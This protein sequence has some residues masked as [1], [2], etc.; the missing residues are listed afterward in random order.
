MLDKLKIGQ[1]AKLA[2]ISVETVRFYE[3]QGLLENPP[4]KESGY[5]QYPPEAVLRI[6]FIKKAKEVGFS[7]KEIKELLSLR[8][9]STTICADVRS[10]AEAKICDIEQ[11]IQA[12]QKM[13]QALAD[14]T[15]A[16]NGDAPVSKCP[17][18]KSLEEKEVDN[19][20]RRI[21]I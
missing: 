12:L 2:G 9:D 21:D 4:R 16:C 11:K 15:A 6:S 20:L 5:R 3:R 14:L 1:V 8:L 17:I 18:L 19:G 10:L 7:L 13:K